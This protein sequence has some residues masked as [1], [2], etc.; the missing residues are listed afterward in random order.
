MHGGRLA[1]RLR[2]SYHG[3]VSCDLSATYLESSGRWTRSGNGDGPS[4]TEIAG[5][6]IA[7]PVA[8]WTAR[9]GSW[10]ARP[11]RCSKLIMPR[12][13]GRVPL[14]SASR[15]VVF[16]EGL[17]MGTEESGPPGGSRIPRW[18]RSIE[19]SPQH[20]SAFRAWANPEELARWFPERI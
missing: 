7:Y 17:V 2:R 1:R 4:S 13:D 8:D 15:R 12:R 3:P 10:F 14:R 19:A 5:A 20:P 18:V 16:R 9:G 6:R 11:R